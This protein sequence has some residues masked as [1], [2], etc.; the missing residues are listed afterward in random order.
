MSFRLL[1]PIRASELGAA[2][3]LALSGPDRAV[4]G[5]CGLDGLV[6]DGLSFVL[7]GRRPPDG[8][9]GT[10]FARTPRPGLSVFVAPNPRLGFIRAQYLLAQ[11]PG[12]E[13]DLTPPR[14]HPTAVVSAGAVIEH[15][16][17][18]GEGTRIAPGAVI[19][20]GTRI[21]RF[22][23]IKSG[24]VLGDQGF[25]FE[26]DEAGRP[27]RMLHMGGVLLGDHV[28]VGSLT[29]VVL[30]ALGDTVLEDYVKLDDH[31]HV[32][33]N[34]RVGARTIITACA[35]LSGSVKIGCDAWIGPNASI[36]Q[37]VTL[38]DGC[39]IGL[40]TVVLHSVEPGAVVCGNPA[41]VLRRVAVEGGAY[42]QR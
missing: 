30:G 5:L 22:C 37:K 28:E 38:G 11:R 9:S 23:E 41:R 26:R 27:L 4:S 15:G 12:F 3:G 14:L 29:T 6:E 42:G 10:V 7:P 18:V 33:H 13:V 21:G 35:E 36:M 24:A 25:G 8:K 19:R 31:V 16:V 1:K 32:A 2:L 40:G 17:T 20:T 39:L 34:C